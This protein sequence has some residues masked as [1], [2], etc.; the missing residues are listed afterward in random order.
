MYGD[1]QYLWGI[2][3]IL[4]LGKIWRGERIFFTGEEAKKVRCI[5]RALMEL[6]ACMKVDER[7]W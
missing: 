3:S 6:K 7:D 2:G 1:K 5:S 4:R